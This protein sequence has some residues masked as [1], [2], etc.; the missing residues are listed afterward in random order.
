MI[1]II[2]A[3]KCIATNV[4]DRLFLH[5]WFLFSRT[6]NDF[7]RPAEI[8]ILVSILYS[9]PCSNYNE[10]HSSFLCLSLA[11]LLVNEIDDEDDRDQDAEA[12]GQR[13]SGVHPHVY[14]FMRVY[15]C[16]KHTPVHRRGPLL[17]T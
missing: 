8:T 3:G 1:L 7:A 6:F 4:L 11:A 5:E 9:I 15:T 13:Y 12:H 16:T 2:S 17:Q 14:T 10:C